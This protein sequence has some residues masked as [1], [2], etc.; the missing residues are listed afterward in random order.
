MNIKD[1]LLGLSV[2]APATGGPSLFP[3]NRGMHGHPGLGLANPSAV[4]EALIESSGL[5]AVLSKAS[6]SESV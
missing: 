6:S 4:I 5:E 1:G 3:Q 2:T